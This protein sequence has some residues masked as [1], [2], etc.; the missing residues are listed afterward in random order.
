M[1]RTAYVAGQFYPQDQE[2]LENSVIE[3]LTIC[4]KED[5][6]AIIV[7][8]AGYIY[9]GKVAGSVYSRIRIPNNIILIG[10]NHTGLGA[11][12]SIM[13][14]G[15]WQTPLGDM[16]INEELACRLLEASSNLT[17]D[18]AAHQKEH[19]LEV[20]LP[21]IYLLNPKASIVPITVMSAGF[22]ECSE[23]GGAIAEVL[24]DYSKE[25]LI[26]I[27]SDLN[28][29]ESEEI[30]LEKDTLA[31]ERILDLDPEGLLA[32]TSAERI[33]MCGAIPSTIGL[34]AAKALGARNTELTEHSTSGKTSGDLE[35]VVG[36]AGIIIK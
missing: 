20:Q 17:E 18:E 5:A 33:S 3:N 13:C 4:T 29:F 24:M 34:I 1:I 8:H 25:V 23:I 26:V 7:P 14:R 10:P 22:E 35:N 15:T 11:P 28:H 36:Y 31:I 27:S 19:S 6:L 12:A 16:E 2:I 21:F 30:T 9:S 32:V